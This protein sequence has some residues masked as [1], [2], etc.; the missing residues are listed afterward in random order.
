MIQ[1]QPILFQISNLR[2]FIPSTKGPMAIINGVSLEIQEGECFGLLGE[3]GSGKTSLINASLGLFQITQRYL[4]A[5]IRSEWAYPFQLEYI[6]RVIWNSTVTGSVKYRGIE[7]LSLTDSERARYLGSH[8]SYIPQGLQGALT[9]VFSIGYQTGE[10]LEIHDADNRRFQMRERVLEF[11]NLV[12][13]ADADRRFVLDPSK[14][15]GG[16]AQRILIAMSLIA[17]PYLVI[18]DEPTSAL[19]V[20]V[21]SQI[22]SLLEMVKE[23]FDIGLMLIS[24]D[25]SVIA[26]LADRVGVLYAGRIV[27]VGDSIQI[28]HEPSH[29]YTQGLMSCYPTIA[30]MQMAAGKKRPVLRGIQGSPPSPREIPQG[31]AFHPRC[32]FVK[33]ECI[34]LKPKLRKINT[35]HLIACHRYEE[36]V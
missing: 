18:A 6:D 17:A 22:I 19:D 2:A 13:L 9:P 11:L 3:S 33:D 7:L 30:M 36:I 5:K 20:T 35:N 16:E 31:C 1:S 4:D 34:T 29:P 25:A 24:H 14:F 28:F 23:E 21:Q 27:E 12:S 32:P 8:I 15:S 26:E 10:P